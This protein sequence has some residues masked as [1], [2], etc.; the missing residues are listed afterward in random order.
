MEK[1][2]VEK[3]ER[4]PCFS[5]ASQIE[6][7]AFLVGASILVLEIAGSRLLAPAFG[8]SIF[9]WTAQIFTV[10]VALS[11][12]YLWGGKKADKKDSY[13]EISK[14]L[15]AASLCLSAALFFSG[16]LLPLSALLGAKFG[17][18]FFS[19]FLFFL[20]CFFAGALTPMLLR[21]YVHE[22]GTVGNDAGKLYAISTIGSMA[23]ALLSAYFIVPFVGAKAGILLTA[24]LFALCAISL[25]KSLTLHALACIVLLAFSSYSL[26]SPTHIWLP[27]NFAVVSE[28][29][30]EYFHFRIAQNQTHRMLLLD[31]DAHSVE[32]INSTALSL[33]YTRQMAAAANSFLSQKGGRSIGM[34]GLGAGSLAANLAQQNYGI[35]VLEIDPAVQQAAQKH[36]GF[37]PLQN[38]RILIGDARMQLSGRSPSEKFSALLIDAFASKFSIPTHLVTKEAFAT[39]AGATEDDSALVMNII[40]AQAGKKSGVFCSISSTMREHFPYQFALR[41]KSRAPDEVQNIVLIGFKKQPAMQALPSQ[42]PNWL[43]VQEWEEGEVFTDD[44]AS[45]DYTM[46]QILE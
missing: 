35:E 21:L 38:V 5:S 31:A 27:Q 39:Y 8:S 16:I 12:G 41:S 18:F 24:A 22:L 37:Q 33:P 15:L 11:L 20:P 34:L 2:T 30:S 36:F 32:E 23:G 17:P 29:D 6:L 1:N 19:A 46:M 7:L 9:V 14:M 43:L 45:V 4:P 25:R 40:S 13:G 10:L 28:Y 44:R 42:N 26:A 3:P